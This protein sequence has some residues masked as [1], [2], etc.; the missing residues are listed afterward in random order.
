MQHKRRDQMTYRVYTGPRGAEE[1]SPLEKERRLFKEF[2]SLDETL[3]WAHYIS[4][5]GEAVLLI[6]GDDGT[7]MTKR[8]IANELRHFERNIAGA[9]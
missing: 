1:I 6:E 8:E 4:D 2:S 9:L 3:A 7:I 5:R